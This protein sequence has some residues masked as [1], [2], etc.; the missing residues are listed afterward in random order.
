MSS[1]STAELIVTVA[2]YYTIYTGFITLF[3]G[4]IG[5]ISLIFVLS[6]L[7]IFRGNPSAFYLITESITNLFQMA[8][9]LT[10][11]IAMN[12]FATD[13]TQ[14]ILFWCRLRSLFRVYFTLKPLSIICFSAI[15]QYL[16]TSYY[17]FLRQKSTMKLAKILITIVTIV[18]V[19]H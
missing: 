10:S 3:F 13:L 7:R 1:S 14:T 17:P 5:N 16:S 12:G 11:R 2:E 19:L 8:V 4:I 18:W 15:D 6:R 9:L